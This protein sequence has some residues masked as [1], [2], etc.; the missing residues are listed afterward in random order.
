MNV[1]INLTNNNTV[2][3]SKYDTFVGV[4]FLVVSFLGTIGNSLTLVVLARTKRLYNHCTPFLFSLAVG[5]LCGCVTSLPVVSHN[6]LLGTMLKSRILCRLMSM[7]LHALFGISFAT[8]AAISAIQCLVVW[9]KG[10]SKLLNKKCIGLLVMM[11]WIVPIVAV[12]PLFFV[13][14]SIWHSGRICSYFCKDKLVEDERYIV[15]YLTTSYAGFPFLVM[16]VCYS[17]IYYQMRISQIS[18]EDNGVVA[19]NIQKRNRNF[20]KMLSFIFFSYVVC[21]FPAMILCLND[22]TDFFF[23]SA[24][25]PEWCYIIC[26]VLV[27]VPFST[28]PLIYVVS[29]QNYRRA[30]TETLNCFKIWNYNSKA[31]KYSN[32]SSISPDPFEAPERQ[33]VIHLS[34]L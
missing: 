11:T 25:V 14:G 10:S 2:Y 9:S 19:F 31:T 6:A 27:V 33:N 32:S 24:S 28:N 29:N 16:G 30:Y 8:V 12:F 21:T 34:V 15:I 7:E 22:K 3:G 18:L 13:F 17:L 4:V 5:N 20:T 23:S 1:S 26:F